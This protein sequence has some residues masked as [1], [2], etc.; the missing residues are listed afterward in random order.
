M[1]ILTFL[2]ILNNVQTELNYCETEKLIICEEEN[3][4]GCECLNTTTSECALS[5]VK[6]IRMTESANKFIL[7][8]MDSSRKKFSAANMILRCG[9]Y[10]KNGTNF[11]TALIE[12]IFISNT[13]TSII[14]YSNLIKMGCS[15]DHFDDEKI[16]CQCIVSKINESN[17]QFMYDEGKVCE[18][19]ES[20]KQV[21]IHK[22]ELISS[23]LT[24]DFLINP[25]ESTLATLLFF[26]A[27]VICCF[28]VFYCCKCL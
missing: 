26:A 22:N 11:V 16:T 19:Y 21:K 6:M 10:Y 14:F 17:F 23:K 7:N 20:W 27:V 2:A 28:A 18:K 5:Q 4:F 3:H 1:Q 24:I 12:K 8:K 9:D 13:T 15:I 25:N